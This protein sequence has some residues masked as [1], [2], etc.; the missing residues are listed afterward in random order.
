[1]TYGTGY[2]G[3]YVVALVFQFGAHAMYLAARKVLKINLSRIGRKITGLD[4]E[5]IADYL[6]RKLVVAVGSANI[7]S[8]Q[9]GRSGYI[10][11]YRAIDVEL[12]DIGDFHL[13]L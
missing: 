13:A 3:L 4:V 12:K 2:V 1:M 5:D 9:R 8:A 7:Y 6:F 11:N 10:V